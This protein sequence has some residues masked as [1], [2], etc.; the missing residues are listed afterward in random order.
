[1]SVILALDVGDVRVG[2]AVCD[3]LGLTVR[4]LEALSRQGG[5]VE[6]SIIA[7]AERLKA[8]KIVVGDP[9]S[10]LGEE[11]GQ[12]RK[13]E[14]FCRR[15]SRRTTLPIERVSEY[16]SSEEAKER[17][18]LHSSSAVEVRASGVIDSNAAAIIL[19][20]YLQGNF[21]IK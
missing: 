5:Q 3:A 20:R 7:L 2:V 15:L 1:L 9:L 17:L 18:G 14:R 16:L 11:T 10:A 12:S 4:P 21:D 13:I 19:E 8:T 6:Q